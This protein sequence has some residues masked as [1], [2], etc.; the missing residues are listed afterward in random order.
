MWRGQ[1]C[2]RRAAPVRLRHITRLLVMGEQMSGNPTCQ[3][4]VELKRNG[5]KSVEL[6]NFIQPSLMPSSSGTE[7]KGPYKF[8]WLR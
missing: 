3:E 7:N 5:F 8:P 2:A 4:L 1:Q 6:M